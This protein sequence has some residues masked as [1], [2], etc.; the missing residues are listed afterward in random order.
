[1]RCNNKITSN[2]AT[3][4]GPFQSAKGV[5]AFI[6]S[7]N[8]SFLKSKRNLS[9]IKKVSY[10]LLSLFLLLL[11]LCRHVNNMYCHIPIIRLFNS[12]PFPKQSLVF[13]CLQY[14]SFETT[15]GKG[16][17]A[18]NKQFLL[19]PHCFLPVIRIFCHFHQI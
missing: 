7:S 14:L 15:A 8:S 1:M 5:P 18:C 16:E 17:I 2:H 19:F 13:T 6:A 4:V 10:N 12:K 9:P 11:L 3:T